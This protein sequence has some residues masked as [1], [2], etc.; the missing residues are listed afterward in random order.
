[1]EILLR[2]FCLFSS[3]SVHPRSLR[4]QRFAFSTTQCSWLPDRMR[5]DN[6]TFY[7]NV[8]IGYKRG[9]SNIRNRDRDI[10]KLQTRALQKL[11][12]VRIVDNGP[13]ALQPVIRSARIIEIYTKTKRHVG[14]VG[15]LCLITKNGAMKRAFIVGQRQSMGILKARMDSNNVI[16]LDKDGNPEGTRITVPIPAWLRGYDPKKKHPISMSKLVAIASS[17]V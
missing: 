16:I 9:H 12:R 15:D 8:Q 3:A 6:Q 5:Y 2:N 7:D 14:G 13:T 10:K 4:L 1:M 17:F 11:T